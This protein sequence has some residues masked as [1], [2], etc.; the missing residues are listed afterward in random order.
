MLNESIFACMDMLHQQFTSIMMMPVKKFN[1]LLKWKSDVEEQR[2]K[3]IE[4]RKR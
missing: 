4:E 2:A 3:L 1:D